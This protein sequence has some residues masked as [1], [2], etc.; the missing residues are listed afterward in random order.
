MIDSAK[1]ISVALAEEGYTEK[2]SNKSLDS[3][4]ANAGCKNYTKYSRDLINE[5][6]GP[7]AQGVAWCDMFVD[8]CFLK[9]YGKDTAKKLIGGWSAYTPTSAQYYKN[10]GRYYKTKPQV[11]DQIFFRNPKEICHTGLIYKVSNSYIYTIEG[12]T[13]PQSGVVANG[14]MVCKKKYMISNARIDGFGRPKYDESQK[15]IIRHYGGTFPLIPP[16]LKYGSKGKEVS[17]LQK[18]LNWYASYGLVVDGEFGKYT[19]SAVREFQAK[20]GLIADG[21]FGPKSLEMAKK[22]SKSEFV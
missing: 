22:I 4:T 6:G 3:K 13:S 18:F 10:M 20:T 21:I 8:W 1:V 17:N 11:G 16:N 14:G 12:N 7:Y 15:P 19:Q 5:I 9:A 2:A